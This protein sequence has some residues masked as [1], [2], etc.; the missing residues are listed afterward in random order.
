MKTVD[1]K[2]VIPSWAEIVRTVN[3]TPIYNMSLFENILSW[4]TYH[5]DVP[6]FD[7][8]G[9]TITYRELP[10]CVN[11][12]ACGLTALGL[13]D[14]D[15]ITMCLPV[16]IE[17]M[18]F[19]LATDYLG[20]I[21]NNVN[22]LFLKNDFDLYTRQ[23]GS[24]VLITLDAYLPF[25]IDHLEESHIECV[26]LTSLQYYLPASQKHRFDDCSS[27]P[28]K[29]KE[30]FDNPDKQRKC[31][32]IAKTL[33]TVRFI[34]FET[35]MEL[36]KS[37][38]MPLRHEPVDVDRDISYSY[39]SGTTGV[40]KCIVYK[41][42]SANAFIEMH[43]GVDTKDLVGER[44]FQVIP[45]THATGERFGGYLQMARGKTLVPQPIYNKET[46]GY[47]LMNSRCN[48]I[49]A[50]AS[51][52]LAGV[53]HGY[54]ANDAFSCITRPCSGGEPI[55]KSNSI[56]INEWLKMNGCQSSF[57]LGGGTAEDG[58]ACF[59]S[60][61]IDEKDRLN[62]TGKPLSPFIKAKVV[63]NC[64]NTVRPGCRG[65]LHISSPAAADRYLDNT[66]A[67]NE[68]WYYDEDGIRWGITGD[69]AIENPDGSY[70]ILG[71][72]DDSYIDEKGNTVYLFDIEYSL[73][74]SDPVIEWEITAHR[75]DTGH[76][77]VG[78]VILKG[79]IPDSKATI[80]EYLCT[81]YH[82]DGIKIYD[83][84]ENSDVTGKRD[85]K[86]LK[87][88]CEG[89]YAPCDNVYLYKI[90]YTDGKKSTKQKVLKTDI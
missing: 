74:E 72:A 78:Q 69:I 77:V 79:N 65:F 2:R 6:A 87:E 20:I 19:L 66:R 67:T 80:V 13:T 63:D 37:H 40:P 64:G 70:N 22:Y 16:S 49:M 35:L 11:Q 5:A 21:S 39:T 4:N 18:M 85:F 84:F 1:I 68:R 17:N 89:F 34:P 90:S 26:I 7:Y 3:D 56:L 75:T 55:T 53:A 45:L 51:F 25:F 54:I 8:Y 33:K 30:I 47:D 42:L 86:K 12:Y 44:V 41:E 52:Y 23:K 83:S 60:Y 29:L 15:I 14:K 81:K 28:K 10:E 62:H 59:F 27:L 24:K 32:E 48:W 71:R 46:F 57:A 82:L 43:N 61:F 73:D 9:T 58:S 36:G 76:E 38:Y 88:D 31:V 50:S